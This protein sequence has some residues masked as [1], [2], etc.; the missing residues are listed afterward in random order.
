[1]DDLNLGPLVG[2]IAKLLGTLGASL[3][4]MAYLMRKF[5]L[6]DKVASATA[7]GNVDVIQA[8]HQ[9]VDRAEKR[10]KDAVDREKSAFDR[11]KLAEE[12]ADTAYKERNDAYREIG[13]LREQVKHL[14][15]TVEQLKRQLDNAAAK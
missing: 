14:T 5:L 13:A 2:N 15:E 4:V 3:G 6:S 7:Q 10:E 9:L 12:R 1:M 11:A 8:L